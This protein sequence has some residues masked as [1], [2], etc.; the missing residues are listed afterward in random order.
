MKRVPSV[1]QQLAEIGYE[2]TPS[3]HAVARP[4]GAVAPA[5]APK[6]RKPV[7]VGAKREPNKTEALL[8]QR[9]RRMFD[10]SH[11][12]KYEA[13]TFHLA[14]GFAYTPDWTVWKGNVLVHVYEAKGAYKFASQNRSVTAF[15]QAALEW[16]D[17]PFT[18]AQLKEGKWRMAGASEP[19][20]SLI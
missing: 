10:S 8:E 2:M 7:N 14:A 1:E 3:G 12:I 4:G 5:P 19:A 6:P 20:E 9:L 16:P 11:S 17:I 15:K 18:W 13:F